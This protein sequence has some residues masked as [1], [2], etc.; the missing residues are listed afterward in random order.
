MN[1]KIISLLMSGALILSS[2]GVL[3]FDVSET[4]DDIR[5]ENNC[6][7]D[8][9]GVTLNSGAPDGSKYYTHS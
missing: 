9:A 5:Y 4:Y 1:K 6:D 3:A 2:A 8:L 7:T